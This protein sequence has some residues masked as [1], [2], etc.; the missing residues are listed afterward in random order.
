MVGLF[1]LNIEVLKCNQ[2]SNNLEL[3]CLF[4]FDE[5]VDPRLETFEISDLL[6][7]EGRLT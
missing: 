7:F 2:L 1:C 6:H 5:D 3:A 4:I